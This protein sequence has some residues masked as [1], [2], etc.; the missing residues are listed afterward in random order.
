MESDRKDDPAEDCLMSAPQGMR[1]LGVSH[2]TWF[3]KLVRDPDFPAPV[4]I[5][6]QRKRWRSELRAYAEA[7]RVK[8]EP[9]DVA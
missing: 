5:G 3:D 4:L 8:R 1:F 9:A 6:Q 2:S 7:R